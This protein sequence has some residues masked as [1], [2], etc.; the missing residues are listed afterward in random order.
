MKKI[1]TILFLAIGLI[2]IK[3]Q[4]TPYSIKGT[5]PKDVKNVFLY[6][7]FG[8]NAIDSATVVDGKFELKGKHPLNQIFVVKINNKGIQM[9]ND[10]TPVSINMVSDTLVGSKLNMKLYSY[11]RQ[12]SKYD[13][14]AQKLYAEYGALTQEPTKESMVK[15]KEIVAKFDSLKT[16]I[17]NEELK[18]V[19]ENKRNLIPAVY[20]GNIYYAL[21]YDE[22]NDLLS[23]S[24]P[25]YNHPSVARAKAQLTALS[26]R[27]PGIIF[28]DLTM[29]DTIGKQRKL[30]EWCGKGNYVLVDFWASWCGPCRQEMPNVVANYNKYHA[31]GFEVVGVSFDNKAES[32][33]NAI[34]NMGMAW[35]NISDL[36]GWQS[37]ATSVYGV[38]AIPANILL[39]GDGIIVAVDLRGKA[40]GDKLKEIYGF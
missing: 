17:I 30:S 20:L 23:P 14:E 2:P 40:L 12:L 37:E 11:D 36:K 19:K 26:K 10:G 9:F 7:S 16:V 1:M 35:P 32:W 39:D 28:K 8:K 22:L 6:T 4:E 15:A 5:V 21:S 24:V 34:K 13:T 18:I 38:N 27:M 33:K 25:Y 3:A 29:N 31:K